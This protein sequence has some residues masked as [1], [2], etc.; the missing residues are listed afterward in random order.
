MFLPRRR[1]I[2]VQDRDKD[3]LGVS[4]LLSNGHATWAKVEWRCVRWNGT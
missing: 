4:K 2:L 3:V 1:V